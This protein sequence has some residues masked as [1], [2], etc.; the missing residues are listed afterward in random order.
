MQGDSEM[1]TQGEEE[2]ALTCTD[3]SA[4]GYALWGQA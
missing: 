1:H 2:I 4:Y 3:S